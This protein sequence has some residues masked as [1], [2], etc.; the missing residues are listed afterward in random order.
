MKTC[1]VCKQEK[2]LSEF[3][4]NPRKKDGYSYDCKACHSEYARAHYQQN[5]ETYR[6]SAYAARDRSVVKKRAFI[7]EYYQNHPCVDCGISDVRVLQS[8][9][10]GDKKHE[11]AQLVNSGYSMKTLIDELAKCVTR[12]ANCHQIKTAEQF[13]LWRHN[14]VI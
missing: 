4:K 13:G 5:K 1:S 9:H 3:S 2:E 12:C 6:V 11:I 10:L 8:D 7:Y 14:Y